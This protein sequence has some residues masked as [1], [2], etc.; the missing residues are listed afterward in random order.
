MPAYI[1]RT[2]GVQF[3][4]SGNPP[5]SCVFC[6]DLRQY[7]GREGQQWTTLAELTGDGQGTVVREEEPGLYGIPRAVD[8]MAIGRPSR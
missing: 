4:E 2:C 8:D 6:A 7:V 1:C 5:D 3:A